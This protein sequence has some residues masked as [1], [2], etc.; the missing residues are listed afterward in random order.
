MVSAITNRGKVFW[1]THER[2]VNGEMFFEF[3]QRLAAKSELYAI[4][5]KIGWKNIK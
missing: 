3:V 5:P 1:K 2:S 4:C